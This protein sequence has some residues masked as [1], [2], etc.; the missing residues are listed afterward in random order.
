MEKHSSKIGFLF[1]V[2]GVLTLPVDNKNPRS[3]IDP[4]IIEY[5]N[6]LLSLKFPMAFV[7]GRG[8]CWIDS[9]FLNKISPLIKENS[10]IFMEYGLVFLQNNPEKLVIQEK[11]FR[12][13]YYSKI[14]GQIDEICKKL[15]ILFEKE[16]VYCDYPS[17]GSLW[18]EDKKVMLSIASNTK[19]S[20]KLVHK[21][22]TKL[23][24]HLKT[25]V[26]IIYHHLGV[27]ILPIGWSKAKAAVHV[28]NLIKNKETINKW[29]V[30]GDN[31][32]D[33]EMCQPFDQVKFINTK[34][35]ASKKTIK[36]LK[37]IVD[38]S[39]FSD[40]RKSVDNRW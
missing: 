18:V 4:S 17:H 33:K 3:I 15:S 34:T 20:T 12:N 37:N 38:F 30:F 25:H 32:S 29:Y 5:L 31:V 21:I 6:K 1:D 24:E 8:Q 39:K 35:G 23:D 19:I 16:K 11:N 26:R 28:N 13:Q 7:T 22:I 2:D 14:L 40:F 27:D 9:N 36:E 10:L